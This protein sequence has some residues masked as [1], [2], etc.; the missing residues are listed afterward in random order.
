MA[1]NVVKK[2]ANRASAMA[3]RTKAAQ[4]TPLPPKGTPIKSPKV[5]VVEA[6]S[7]NDELRTANGKATAFTTFAEEHGWEVKRKDEG[8]IIRVVVSKEDERYKE[9]IEVIWIG[10]RAEPL[11]YTCNGRTLRMQN[12]SAARQHINGSKPV[13]KDAQ[14]RIIRKKARRLDGDGNPVE[15]PAEKSPP[16][17]SHIKDK[18]YKVQA[19]REVKKGKSKPK[20]VLALD[21]FCGPQQMRNAV[22]DWTKDGCDVRVQEVD[23][24]NGHAVLSEEIHRA[25]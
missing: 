14:P 12:V 22:R 8:D 17:G 7:K 18:W 20:R 4:R 1:T 2:G 11:R 21:T 10:G 25:Q 13:K 19:V 24:N 15:A 16:V 6:E 3:K 23:V 9:S 5:A